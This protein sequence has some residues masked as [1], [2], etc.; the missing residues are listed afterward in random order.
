M[1]FASG[2][3]SAI[4]RR[5]LVSPRHN[6][7][8]LIVLVLVLLVAAAVIATG[9]GAVEIEPGR[10][11]SHGLAWLGLPYPG[12]SDF[13]AAVFFS[14]RLPRTLVAILVG[15]TLAVAGVLM[16]TF[17]R[18]PLAEPSI[19]GVASGGALGAV[20][21]IVIGA[22]AGIW[23]GIPPQ[24][25]LPV[26]AFIGSAIVCGAIL[27]ISGDEDGI[28]STKMLLSGIA[29]NA[30]AGAGIGLMTFI[31]DD[32]QLR[33]MTFWIMGSLSAAS[34]Q[35][36]WVLAPVFVCTMAFAYWFALPLNALLLGD[37]AAHYLGLNV[38]LVKLAVICLTCLASATVV[39]MCGVIGFVG[40]IAPH[41]ARLLVGPDHRVLLPLSLL[42]GALLMVGA[43]TVARTIVSPSELPIGILTA[44]AGGPV[45]LWL[46]RR[47]KAH[48]RYDRG[49][50]H[51]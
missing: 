36:L 34:W 39:A 7:W 38:R 16:Q 3:V 33:D 20:A 4:G 49:S 13:E 9:I 45:F 21:W 28:D 8:P 29:I 10:I 22:S 2:V 5:R 26:A 24:F 17:F 11:V 43:D 15:S 46:L 27:L 47:K 50:R 48:M 12:L 30:I 23:T 40:L 19:V 25:A 37:G 18:N 6:P 35:Q 32:A 41:A 44:L 51:A 1:S 31:A 14:I 42:L